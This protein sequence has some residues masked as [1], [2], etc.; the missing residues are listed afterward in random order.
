MSIFLEILRCIL[1][2]DESEEDIN[3]RTSHRGGN[4]V[5][6]GDP[7]VRYYPIFSTSSV[8]AYSPPPAAAR[9]NRFTTPSPSCSSH[10]QTPFSNSCKLP[11][12]PSAQTSRQSCPL[13]KKSPDNLNIPIIIP[14]QNIDPAFLSVPTSSK[15]SSSR[16]KP[17]ASKTGFDN[18]SGISQKHNILPP[19][20]TCQNKAITKTT[21]QK[22][23]QPSS[24]KLPASSS[25][26]SPFPPPSSRKPV[27]SFPSFSSPHKPSPTS[28]TTEHRP[29][30][31]SSISSSPKLLASSPKAQPPN[32][33]P[34]KFPSSPSPSSFASTSSLTQK[35]L[36]TNKPFLSLASSNLNT[37]QGKTNYVWVQK[38]SSPI[39][40]IP[41]RLKELISQD[42]VPEVLKMPLSPSSY[43]CYFDALLYAEDFYIEKWDGFI[44]KNVTLELHEADVYKRESKYYNQNV[45]H[46]KD[47]KVFVV[48]K[49]DSVPE[50]RPFLLSRDFVSVWPS[51]SGKEEHFQGLVY[52]VVKS[53]IVL[54]EFGEDFHKQHYTACKY[55]VK[56]SFNRVC[57][58]RGHQAIA[59]AQDP[60]F[61]NFLFPEC[62]AAKNVSVA[63]PRSINQELELKQVAAVHQILSHQCPQPYLVEGPSSV[64]RRK[65]LSTTGQVV[66]E[67]VLQI[68]Q[69]CPSCRILIC[70]PIN[71][72][73]DII[74]SNLKKKK[75][76]PDSDMF[77]A[78]AAFRELDGVP[79]DILPSCL[80]KGECFS[81]PSLQLLRK[82][83]VILSTFT[84][85]F[86]LHNEGIMAGHFSHIFL[87]DASSATEPETM[88]ALANLASEDTAVIVTGAPRKHSG[89]VRSKMARKNGLMVS[90]FERLRE[91]KPYKSL[92][93]NAIAVLGDG[94]QKSDDA[95]S[96]LSYW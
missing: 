9:S 17:Q 13:V 22:H 69:T 51:D 14:K 50:R 86:R 76:I 4:L 72:T 44:M 28:I 1:C 6:S 2:C 21:D 62:K 63:V 60:L 31:P 27:S 57:L 8:P 67:A 84:S 40:A 24:S 93:P 90:Y 88:V 20:P 3:W 11:E 91:S 75:V 16:S 33:S 71:S 54:A 5:F 7:D 64:D 46:E 36:P 47:E 74:M 37:P 73:C 32:P 56:F 94:G 83:K 23:P 15:T 34:E 82:Y 52:R 26:S 19:T 85:S 48:F 96:T 41:E 61:R 38:D 35:P 30:Q 49:L 18:S 78:N 89:W 39:Y 77:R 65:K 45:S 42:V 66:C 12:T 58:K 70:A 43:Q 29:P 68:C 87:V 53:D 79:L 10:A 95:S 55:N 81:C 59:A 80:Y 25:T 92:E